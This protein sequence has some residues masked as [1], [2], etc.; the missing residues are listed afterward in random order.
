MQKTVIQRKRRETECKIQN[1]KRAGKMLMTKEKST[2]KNN[3]E[4]K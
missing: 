1:A 2:T 3:C 4:T